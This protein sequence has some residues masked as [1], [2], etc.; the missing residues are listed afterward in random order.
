MLHDKVL[1]FRGLLYLGLSFTKVGDG[2][3]PMALKYL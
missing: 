3:V 1:N 2:G